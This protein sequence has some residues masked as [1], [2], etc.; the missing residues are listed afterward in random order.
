MVPAITL[1]SLTVVLCLLAP[2]L[3]GASFDTSL[4]KY[5]GS[6][7][8][9]AVKEIQALARNGD[10]NAQAFLGAIYASGKGLPRDYR[11]ALDWQLK[12]AK[13][14]HL[15][16]QYNIAVMYSK[17]MGTTQDLDK[18]ARWFE[19][20]ARQGLPEARMHLGLFH[21]KGWV[22]RKCPFAASEQYYEAGQDYLRRGDLKG[23]RNAARAIHKI[24]PK[25]Y[26]SKKLL[27]EIYMH[28]K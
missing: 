2:A 1:R 16:A 3:A 11:A 4:K 10:I 5:H 19:A 15:N 6:Q 7:R 25:Y 22:L 9:Q 18:A 28:E 8:S 20:A 17:G 24:L 13:K 26:L 27:T 23:A 12:A 14:G 21:E